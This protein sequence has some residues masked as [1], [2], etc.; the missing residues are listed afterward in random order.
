MGA[1]SKTPAKIRK[2][3]NRVWAKKHNTRLRAA[4]WVHYH[5]ELPKALLDSARSVSDRLGCYQNAVMRAAITIGLRY[6]RPSD[7]VALEGQWRSIVRLPAVP[8][9]PGRPFDR[10]RSLIKKINR[11]KWQ[12]WRAERER[13]NGTKSA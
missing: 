7:V 8:R 13:V 1:F 10:D 11:E 3:R 12:R 5:V 9:L 6:L 4:G 2:A